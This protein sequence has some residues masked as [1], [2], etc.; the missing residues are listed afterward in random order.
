V[1]RAPTASLVVGVPWVEE[2]R[3]VTEGVADSSKE[4][5]EF[6]GLGKAEA[7]VA[8]AF[9]RPM[10]IERAVE[11][12]LRPAALDE[13]ADG[14]ADEGAAVLC[15][16]DPDLTAVEDVAC[17]MNEAPFFE[18]SEHA[19]HRRAAHAEARAKVALTHLAAELIASVGQGVEQVEAR[20]GEA[21]LREQWARESEGGVERSLEA[22][23]LGIHDWRWVST[24]RAWLS[25]RPTEIGGGLLASGGERQKAPDREQ[26]NDLHRFEPPCPGQ[27]A[28]HRL[29]IRPVLVAR[30]PSPDSPNPGQPGTAPQWT[31]VE[32]ALRLA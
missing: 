8:P 5:V 22:E 19:T 20:G 7:V 29:S 28:P 15:Q 31:A 9:S 11:R 17:A 32:V 27:E 10:A 23:E 12:E 21:E 2:G 24:G 13:V 14:L 18:R 30:H 1:T 26:A 4:P 25:G 6:F 3:E 16:S